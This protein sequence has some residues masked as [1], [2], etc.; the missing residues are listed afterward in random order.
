MVVCMDFFR[1]F[2]MLQCFGF[3]VSLLLTAV[4]LKGL[5]SQAAILVEAASGAVESELQ[6]HTM[7]NRSQEWSAQN[8][9]YARELQQSMSAWHSQREVTRGTVYS[10]GQDLWF[11]NRRKRAAPAT[12]FSTFYTL[13]GCGCCPSGPRLDVCSLQPHD[14]RLGQPAT[15]QPDAN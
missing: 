7:A 8:P 12:W 15:S 5:V 4:P 14:Q 6:G 11:A 10:A 1:S 13:D 3:S 2:K 9:N